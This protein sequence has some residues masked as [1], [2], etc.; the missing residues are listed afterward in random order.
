MNKNRLNELRKSRGLKLS[1]MPKAIGIKRQTY[2]N[3]EYGRRE[4]SLATWEK[5]AKFY[6]VTPAYLVGWSDE[7]QN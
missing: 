7:K 4:P 2:T 5:L 1:E 3:Y 6:G